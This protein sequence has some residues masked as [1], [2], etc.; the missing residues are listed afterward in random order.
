MGLFKKQREALGDLGDI[1][2]MSRQMPRPKL[3][4]ALRDANALMGQT[5]EQ[6]NL[7]ASGVPGEALVENL[8]DT[9]MTLNDNPVVEF[10]LLVTI[11]GREPYR[12]AHREMVPRLAPNMYAVGMK[13]PVRVD[14]GDPNKLMF[15]F[16]AQA[17]Q[18]QAIG[19]AAMAQ[20]QGAPAGGDP[21]ARL[22]RLAQL[23]QQGALS[24]SEF[25]AQKARILQEM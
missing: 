5:I 11:P 15:D 13:Y 3:G 25:A 22:E 14:P 1:V 7:R 20:A 10:Q 17:A 4:D 8:A 16:M 21:M 6:N 24:D 23:H 19:N 18:A 12:V 2:A 9:G